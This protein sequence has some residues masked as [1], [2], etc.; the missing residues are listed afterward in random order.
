MLG[1]LLFLLYV[2]DI[3][4]AFTNATPKLFADDINL[5]IFHK[6][7]KTLYSLANAELESLNEWLIANK[8][9]LSIGDGKDTKYTLFAPQ[10]YPDTNNLTELHSQAN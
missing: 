1:P 4:N 8:L 7:L 5:F 10:N 6:D 2:N 9:S 3:Q